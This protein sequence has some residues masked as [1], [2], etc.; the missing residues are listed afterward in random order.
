MIDL[1]NLGVKLGGPD[2]DLSHGF[3][4]AGGGGAVGNMG[5]TAENMVFLSTAPTPVPRPLC[6]MAT[7]AA[8]SPALPTSVGSFCA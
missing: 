7:S 5:G 6:V 2:P 4:E 1:L 3:H 8:T